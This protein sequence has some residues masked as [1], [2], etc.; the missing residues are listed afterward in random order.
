M[1]F[2]PRC[3]PA[4][5]SPRGFRA[6]VA[7][8]RASAAGVAAAGLPS[9]AQRAQARLPKERFTVDG[10][11]IGAWASHKSFPRKDGGTGDGGDFHGRQQKNG[12]HASRTEPDAKL[13]RK[14]N[15][16]AGASELR[17]Q[18][19]RKAAH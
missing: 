16:Q 19:A 5:Q 4:R 12:T 15:G 14:P 10:T 9:G 7:P 17:H 6:S 1:R 13:Y 3:R 2:C 18:P 8:A 11:L